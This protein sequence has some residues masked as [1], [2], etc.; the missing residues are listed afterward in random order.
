MYC[1]MGELKFNTPG[2]V[3]LH[4]RDCSLSEG[5]KR[6]HRN[7]EMLL[8]RV[9]FFRMRETPETLNKE[10]RR[11]KPKARSVD[12]GIGLTEVVAVFQ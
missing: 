5:I 9:F 4:P 6:L 11:R 12:F 7:L 10:H 8:F 1:R 3:F 2:L